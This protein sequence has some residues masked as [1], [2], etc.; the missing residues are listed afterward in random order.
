MPSRHYGF[1]LIEVLIALV[2]TAVGLLG[3]ASLQGKAQLA[4]MESYQR[5]QALILL[6]DMAGRLRANRAGRAAYLTQVGY[7]SSFNDTASCGNPSGKTQAEV[8][9][10]C[11]HNALLG[12]AEIS[13][14]GANVGAMLGG[15]GCIIDDD[16]DDADPRLEGNGFI[17]SVSWQGMNDISVSGSDARSASSCGTGLYGTESRRRVISVP[18]RFI[19]VNS[20]IGGGS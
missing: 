19:N 16:A 6:Q 14:G 10:S 12:A 13:S 3:M 8:D 18:V 17:V 15:H 20:D 1:G 2:I 4:E 11:W 5:A 9:L 7:G